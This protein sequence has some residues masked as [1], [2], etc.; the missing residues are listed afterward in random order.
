[1]I[2][3]KRM[4][5]SVCASAGLVASV[6][7]AGLPMPSGIDTLPGAFSGHLPWR[8]GMEISPAYVLPTNTFL[9]G[10][11]MYEQKVRGTFTGTVRGDFMFNPHSKEGMLYHGLYQGIGMDVRTFFSPELLGTPVSLY[12]Y[13]GAPLK[14]FSPRLWLGYEWRFGAAFGWRDR[15]H[16]M[17]NGY[18][19]SAITTRVTAHLGVSLKLNYAVAPG[20]E[21][22]LGIDATHFSNGN[23]SF[24]NSGINTV[25][26]SIGGAYLFNAS[27]ETVAAPAELTEEADRG[28]WMWDIAA[29]G[30]WRKRHVMIEDT[31]PLLP[32]TY[33]VAGML[34]SP[35]RRINRWFAAGGALDVQYDRSAGL[36]PYWLGG[37][38]E[39][40]R[41]A[42]PPFCKQLRI[43][44]AGVAEFS[45][46]IF[47]ISAGIGYDLLSPH[48]EMK[49]F[50]MLTVK[51]FVTRHLFLNVGYRLGNFKDPQ[52]LMLGLGV[53]I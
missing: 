31:G 9:T 26:I 14:Y 23:T 44:I 47:A 29:Y 11:N 41:F 35:M 16:D 5:L 6:S 24:P 37:Y 40:A 22:S 18:V 43:G 12:V 15:S 49:F 17:E 38:Y 3:I 20:W 19:N 28:K 39:E 52:N 48:G 34:F 42:R 8:V 27:R 46:P 7:A 32:G 50:Q 33:G 36:S 45:M 30:A 21:L 25:G 53:R 2:L 51:A 10:D 4:V 13:Q 1:M